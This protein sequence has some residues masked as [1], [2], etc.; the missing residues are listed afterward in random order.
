MPRKKQNASEDQ[1]DLEEA[2][3]AGSDADRGRVV[4]SLS[5]QKHEYARLASEAERNGM[6]LSTYIKKLVLDPKVA[7][8]S[9]QPSI[10]GTNDGPTA[11]VLMGV[12]DLGQGSTKANQRIDDNEH[13]PQAVT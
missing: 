10:Y 13:R 3:L 5:L 12:T 8:T 11:I 1:W 6:K 7:E 4:V 9:I 2:T